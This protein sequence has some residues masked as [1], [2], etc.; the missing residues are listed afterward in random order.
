MSRNSSTGFKCSKVRF[1]EVRAAVVHDL[2]TI[3]LECTLCECDVDVE[4]KNR[5]RIYQEYVDQGACR[6]L[7][8]A[9][10]FMRMTTSYFNVYQALDLMNVDHGWG[11]F[12]C[13]GLTRLG[14]IMGG[15]RGTGP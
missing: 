10:T 7:H 4:C 1:D 11:S 14:K 5:T 8:L 13:L 3:L 15:C 9:T 6:G 12:P 2:H